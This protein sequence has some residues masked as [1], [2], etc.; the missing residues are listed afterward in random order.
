MQTL[1]PWVYLVRTVI[2]FGLGRIRALLATIICDIPPI[3]RLTVPAMRQIPAERIEFGKALGATDWIILCKIELPSTSPTLLAALN[4]CI[5]VC[6]S[7]AVLAGLVGAGGLGSEAAR[8]LS[9]MDMG[10]GTRAGLATAMLAHVMDRASRT[11][12][13]RAALRR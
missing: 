8:G 6:L 3:V 7:I 11:G 12:A 13:R 5:L 2:M 4:Q 1:P 10:L 9:R